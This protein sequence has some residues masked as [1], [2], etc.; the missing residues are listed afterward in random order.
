MIFPGWFRVI[1]SRSQVLLSYRNDL[2]IFLLTLDLTILSVTKA[3][4]SHCQMGIN[5]LS[6]LTLIQFNNAVNES[7]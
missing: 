1:L 5:C 7:G 3:T 2:T 4:L 6:T